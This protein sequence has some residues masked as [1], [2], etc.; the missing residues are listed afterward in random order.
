MRCLFRFFLEGE[1]VRIEEEEI[2]EF[3][4]D[5]RNACAM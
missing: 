2:V 3:R 4:F 5:P 1:G